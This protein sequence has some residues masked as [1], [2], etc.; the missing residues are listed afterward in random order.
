MRRHPVLFLVTLLTLFW[1]S[2]A[3]GQAVDL[4]RPQADMTGR[5]AYP[6][7]Y[8]DEGT[9]TT[10]FT[11]T[12]PFLPR[13]W[14]EA[15]T[16]LADQGV[17]GYIGNAELAPPEM[18]IVPS[19]ARTIRVRDELLDSLNYAEDST[20]VGS[21]FSAPTIAYALIRSK[22]VL[23]ADRYKANVPLLRHEAIH[24]IVWESTREYGHP[25]KYFDPC[26]R[27]HA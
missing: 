7:L 14:D 16:C 26:D 12:M 27:Y 1:V 10:A 19:A 18:R 3:F 2:C 21:R 13:A 8:V 15:L 24:F 22:A 23:V 11:E 6:M 5:E 17:V 9:A 25:P 4:A 20:F